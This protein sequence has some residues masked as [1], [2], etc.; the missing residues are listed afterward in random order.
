MVRNTKTRLSLSHQL[1]RL[2]TTKLPTPTSTTTLQQCSIQSTYDSLLRTALALQQLA[3]VRLAVRASNQIDPRPRLTQRTVKT[4]TSIYQPRPTSA[5]H[6]NRP[7]AFNDSTDL[8]FPQRSSS[9]I[10]TTRPASATRNDRPAAFN[11]STDLRFLQRSSSCILR[12]DQPQLP[13]TIVQLHS[14]TQPTA[15]CTKHLAVSP[16][17]D[18]RSYPHR[19]S[20]C[21]NLRLGHTSYRHHPSS[22]RPR[23]NRHGLYAHVCK[24]DN[25]SSLLLYLLPRLLSS[26]IV[27]GCHYSHTLNLK[28]LRGRHTYRLRNKIIYVYIWAV[29]LHIWLNNIDVWLIN[30]PQWGVRE[31]VAINIRNKHP[32]L[33]KFNFES[34]ANVLKYL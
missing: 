25:K 7:A 10:Q 24:S 30:L 3:Y 14:T 2:Y 18:Q 5:T 22:W 8:S 1:T 15:T 32:K 23:Y 17:L 34:S 33:N 19:T 28:H 13:A 16:R 20:T 21:A 29:F 12:L 11:D 27:F 31:S 6:N 9:C 26:F 4:G